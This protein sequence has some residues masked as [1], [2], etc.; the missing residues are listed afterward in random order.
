M[1]DKCEILAPGVEFYPEDGTILMIKCPECGRENWALQVASG[2]CAWC[3]FDGK[4]LLKKK[5]DGN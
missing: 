5:E 3:G 2:I 4:E 1:K